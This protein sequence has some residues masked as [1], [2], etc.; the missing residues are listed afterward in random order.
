[1]PMTYRALLKGNQLEWQDE[2]PAQ[3]QEQVVPVQVTLLER[4]A[5]VQG[6]RMAAALEKLAAL[7]TFADE[8]DPAA[9]ERNGRQERELPGR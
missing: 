6:E 7:R 9:W 8:D 5:T 4:D 2:A 3:A 1:M